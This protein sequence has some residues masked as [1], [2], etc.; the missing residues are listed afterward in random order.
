MPARAPKATIVGFEG[1][2]G[3]TET[4]GDITGGNKEIGI[5]TTGQSGSVLDDGNVSSKR[6]SDGLKVQT[7]KLTMKRAVPGRYAGVPPWATPIIFNSG[8]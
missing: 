5:L 1:L 7:G 8:A 4:G 2:S 3:S 6:R